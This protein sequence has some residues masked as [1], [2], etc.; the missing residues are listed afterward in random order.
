MCVCVCGLERISLQPAWIGGTFIETSKSF[1]VHTSM[2]ALLHTGLKKYKPIL[3]C[4][5][6]QATIGIC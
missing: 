6:A 2:A 5:A 3:Y 1:H 4:K